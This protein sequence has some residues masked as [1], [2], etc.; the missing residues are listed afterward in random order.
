MFNFNKSLDL[1]DLPDICI[2][3]ICIPLHDNRPVPPSLSQ[4]KIILK[5]PLTKKEYPKPK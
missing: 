4:V 2:G 1:V 3:T 5:Y